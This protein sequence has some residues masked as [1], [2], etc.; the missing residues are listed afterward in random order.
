[1]NAMVA[2]LQPASSTFGAIDINHVYAAG[3]S[4]GGYMSSRIA[5]EYAGG[6][7]SNG[8][9]RSTNMPFRA[10][11]I[12]SGSYQ[13]CSGAN[14]TVP[15][16]IANTNHAPT[17]FLHDPLDGTVPYDTMTLYY[18]QLN[19]QFDGGNPAYTVNGVQE[20]FLRQNMDMGTLGNHQWSE[21]LDATS[22]NLIVDWFNDHR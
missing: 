4:S 5:N 22:T 3:I 20:E 8:T 1:M 7:N 10:V 9:V 14:C 6:L 15:D 2:A 16:P 21:D 13:T 18:D 12:Q 19:S 11:A 17:F